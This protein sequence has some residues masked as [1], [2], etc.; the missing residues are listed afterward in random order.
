MPNELYRQMNAGKPQGDPMGDTFIGFMNQ[1]RGQN[2]RQ[3]I[4]RMVQ[5]GRIT[6]QQLNA[7]QQ[8]AQEMGDVFG[9]FKARFGF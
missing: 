4:D 5:S 3:I 2:P 6:Q 7:V 8:K 9:Q 1:M